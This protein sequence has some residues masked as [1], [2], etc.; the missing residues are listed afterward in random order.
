MN[1]NRRSQKAE[2]AS[3]DPVPAVSKPARH[4]ALLVEDHAALAEA[5]AELMRS[6]GLEV[7]VATTGR[8]ALA[9]AGEFKPAL[10]VCDIMLPDM[11]GLD[12]GQAL[13]AERGANDLLIAVVSAMSAV[14][15]R[16]IEHEWKP[17]GIDVFLSK[18]LTNETLIGLV[19]KLEGHWR[20]RSDVV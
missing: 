7:R 4:R 11:T 12:L 14:D 2:V 1:R 17:R 6:Q 13:R 19:S 15:L 5:T 20:L 10:I 3:L 8:A 16:D 9:M 18:P